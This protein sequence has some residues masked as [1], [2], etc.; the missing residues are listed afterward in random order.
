MMIDVKRILVLLLLCLPFTAVA[1]KSVVK[2]NPLSLPLA[3]VNLAAEQYL[4]KGMSLQLG[5]YYTTFRFKEVNYS[6]WSL[7]PEM[8]F[9]I[10]ATDH[11]SPQGWYIA[12]Y[13]RYTRMGIEREATS[14][15]PDLDGHATFLGGGSL[16]GHQW[17]LGEKKRVSVDVFAGPRYS[18]CI[19]VTGN[20]SRKDFRADFI[21]G[22]G[23]WVRSGITVGLAF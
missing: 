21:I 4:G 3:T 20:A 9:Y 2:I 12:P 15:R 8:R 19:S 14:E 5:A 6:G 13:A 7:T 22:G 10:G 18:R 16:V 11:E 17:L 23:F 1:Q